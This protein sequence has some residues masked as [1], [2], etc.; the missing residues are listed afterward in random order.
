MDKI[1]SFFAMPFGL[2]LC[3]G[4]ALLAWWLEERKSAAEE[5]RNGHK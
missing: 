1:P 3:F 5:K 2:F 4:P